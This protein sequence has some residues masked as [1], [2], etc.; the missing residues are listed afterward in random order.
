METILVA[1]DDKRIRLLLETEL[2]AEGYQVILTNDGLEA[3]KKI[4]E[5]SPD[6]EILDIKM[7]HM[8]GLEVL[9]TM[10]KEDKELPVIICTAYAKMRNDYTVWASRVADYLTKP[11]VLKKVKVLVRR[12]LEA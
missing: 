7:P 5:E 4:E 10:R 1:D 3:L 8:H 11:F 12:A 9:K 6:L 2:T